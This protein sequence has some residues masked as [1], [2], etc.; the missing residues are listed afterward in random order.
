MVWK[1]NSLPSNKDTSKVEI[2]QKYYWLDSQ[3]LN[4]SPIKILLVWMLNILLSN[5]DRITET[6]QDRYTDRNT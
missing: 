3:I 5:V 1:S 6:W 2:H 4:I